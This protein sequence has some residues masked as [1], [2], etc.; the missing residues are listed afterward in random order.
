MTPVWCQN[1]ISRPD[2]DCRAAAECSVAEC[3][4][5]RATEKVNKLETRLTPGEK[6][7]HKRMAQVAAV[8]SVERWNRKPADLLHVLRAPETE[9]NRPRPRNKRVWSSVEKTPRAVIRSMFDE[10]LRQDPEKVRRWVALVDG[11]PKQLRAVKDEARRTGVQVTL[12]LDVVHVMEYVWK[13]ARAPFGASTPDAE[14]W[15]TRRLLELFT[16]K[17]AAPSLGP[18]AGGPSAATWTMRRAKP[19]RRPAATSP[20]VHARG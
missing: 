19:S 12:I 10:A 1:P 5:L 14:K 17:A 6:S 15:V 18:F 8:F 20:T 9:K 2:D 11:E 4:R 3:G 13:A 7:N 16:G